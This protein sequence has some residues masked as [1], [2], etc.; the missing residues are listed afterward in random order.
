MT[1]DFLIFSY[2]RK[3]FLIYDF[4]PAPFRIF[5]YTRKIFPDFSRVCSGGNIYFLPAGREGEMICMPGRRRK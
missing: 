5:L 2:F 1:Y 3:H 4:A